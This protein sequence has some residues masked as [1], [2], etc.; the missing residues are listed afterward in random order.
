MNIST[1]LLRCIIYFLALAVRFPLLGNMYIFL[2]SY[3][4]PFVNAFQLDEH[5]EGHV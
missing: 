3:M 1:Q 5:V 4:F 2:F